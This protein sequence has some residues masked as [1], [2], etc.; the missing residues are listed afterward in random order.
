MKNEET[1]EVEVVVGHRELFGLAFILVLVLAMTFGGGYVV[2]GNAERA[3]ARTKTATSPKLPPPLPVSPPAA[4]TEVPAQAPADLHVQPT[5]RPARD[6][7]TSAPATSLSAPPTP[8]PSA[9]QATLSTAPP[10]SYLQV[11][12]GTE[13]EAQTAMQTLREKG[14]RASLSPGPG[15]L[16]RV[17]VG[18][19]NDV[20]AM[21]KDK[22]ELEDAGLHPFRK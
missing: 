10:G 7:T 9:P 8:V 4:P 16:V 6:S 1:G 2:G 19:Y 11:A 20:Q 14:F 22:K 17:L 21:D 12:A 5:T 18:P 3:K 15:N 13:S